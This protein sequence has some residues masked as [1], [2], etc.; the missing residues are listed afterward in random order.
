MDGELS[1]RERGF[2]LLRLLAIFIQKQHFKQVLF[3]DIYILWE[4]QKEI[5]S[6]E[7][8]DI[9][10]YRLNILYTWPSLCQ[11]ILSYSFLFFLGIEILLI[12][13][14]SIA[15]REHHDQGNS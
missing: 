9:C 2:S 3:S 11:V 4:T 10:E 14:L 13:L 5:I 8:S 15:V 6:A 12:Q 1:H 7:F